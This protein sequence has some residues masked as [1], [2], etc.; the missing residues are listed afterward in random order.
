MTIDENI[1]VALEK[2]DEAKDRA[3]REMTPCESRAVKALCEAVEQ[4]AQAI[5][6]LK[7]RL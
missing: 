7:G 1:R 2:I 3:E 4:L 5:D 6:S